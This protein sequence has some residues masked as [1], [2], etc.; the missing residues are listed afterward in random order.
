MVYWIG[1]ELV[2]FS[3]PMEKKSTNVCVCIEGDKASSLLIYS[4]LSI[5]SKPQNK[6]KCL[7]NELRKQSL[8]F[9]EHNIQGILWWSIH[10]EVEDGLWFCSEDENTWIFFDFWLK[11]HNRKNIKQSQ[12]N[13]KTVPRKPS[14]FFWI[15]IIYWHL[16]PQAIDWWF[17]GSDFSVDWNFLCDLEE[18]SYKPSVS[19][20]RCVNTSLQ[21]LC[22]CGWLCDAELKSANITELLW[23]KWI[24]A[25][26]FYC[27][28]GS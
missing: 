1:T 27:I 7:V 18:K 26:N 14:K 12:H 24:A 9:S 16:K 5:L 19:E 25:P 17:M 20:N 6:N 4:V 21:P 3:F 10:G 13:K 28:I 23:W 8:F 11:Y 2:H 22:G 15:N